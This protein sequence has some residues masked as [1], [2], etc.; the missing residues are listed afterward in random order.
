MI[1]VFDIIFSISALV[2]FSPMLIFFFIFDLFRSGS[3]IFL[4]ARIGKNEKKFM[5]YK[6]RTMKIDTKSAATHLISNSA[7]TPYGQLLRYSKIDELPQLWNV[8]I[9]DMSLVGPRPCL[10]SQHTLIRE[11]RKRKIFK[12]RPGITGLAQIKGVDMSKPLLLAQ[13]D[14]KMIKKM[15][16]LLYFY[17]L[18]MTVIFVFKKR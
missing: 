11:R 9:G 7:I 3:P 14:Y 15:N 16:L 17:Y 10:I 8:I 13:T 18:I 1:R 12:V 6:F 5:L 2:L 4:Q